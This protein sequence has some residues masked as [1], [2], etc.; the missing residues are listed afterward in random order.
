MLKVHAQGAPQAVQVRPV[1]EGSGRHCG[2]HRVTHV[3]GRGSVGVHQDRAGYTRSIL[4]Q[5]EAASHKLLAGAAGSPCPPVPWP[6][7]G[8]LRETQLPHRCC[9]IGSV[10]R[11]RGLDDTGLEQM[12]E[13]SIPA[14]HPNAQRAVGLH[15]SQAVSSILAMTSG[16]YI[17]GFQSLPH[18]MAQ[19]SDR[20]PD[21]SLTPPPLPFNIR[22]NVS[23]W[24]RIIIVFSNMQSHYY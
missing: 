16:T 14:V 5:G 23:M 3:P 11:D 15:F 18:P 24:D 2:S 22:I 4:H 21:G 6:P 19:G 1:W 20:C 9:H 8:G 17:V 10:G 7:P 13:R 12:A